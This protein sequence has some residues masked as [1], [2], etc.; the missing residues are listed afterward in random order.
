M[1]FS[2]ASL[3][4]DAGTTVTWTWGSPGHSVTSGT[5]CV[6]DGTFDSSIQGAGYVFTH[7]FTTPGTYGYFCTPH[8]SMGMAG[9]VVVN[10]VAMTV[11]VGQGQ[12]VFSPANLTIRAGQTVTWQWAGS[13]VSLDS[14]SP[15]T[16]DNQFSSHGQQGSGFTLT[17]TF[18]RPG[19]YTYFTAAQPG[20]AGT[21]TITVN[22]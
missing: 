9:T 7:A 10:A 22:P 4:V 14:G 3:T 19:T 21:G 18:S 1:S 13:G 5:G 8:C 6:P 12:P 16:P 11:M 17:H 15:S 2:P 20:Q